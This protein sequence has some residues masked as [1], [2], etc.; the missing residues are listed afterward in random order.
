[1]LYLFQQINIYD[2]DKKKNY[3]RT[4]VY[5]ISELLFGKKLEDPLLII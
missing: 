2:A 4:K 3:P 1:M 5:K